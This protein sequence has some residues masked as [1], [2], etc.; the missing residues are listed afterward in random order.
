MFLLV[1]RYAIFLT[2]TQLLYHIFETHCT[3]PASAAV[4]SFQ[5]TTNV[6]VKYINSTMLHHVAMDP[7]A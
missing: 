2:S 6:S 4:Y 3:Y 5:M 7:I 1:L